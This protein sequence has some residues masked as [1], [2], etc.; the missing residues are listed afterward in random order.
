M[1]T[2]KTCQSCGKPIQGR[3][4]KKF[5]DDYCRNNFNNQLNGETNS[6]V[7]KITGILKKNRRILEETL[8]ENVEFVKTNLEKLIQQG[9]QTQ[10]HTHTY[11]NKKGDIYQFCFEYGYLLLE[12]NAVL[13]VRRK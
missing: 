4:D 13:V 5:C 6:F 2:E 3:A 10:Y 12:G 8:P 1:N 11:T 7:K 9:F